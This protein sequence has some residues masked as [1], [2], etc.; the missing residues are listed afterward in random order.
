MSVGRVSP[1]M[2]ALR[3]DAGGITGTGGT[4]VSL[5]ED[6]RPSDGLDAEPEVDNEG[7]VVKRIPARRCIPGPKGYCLSMKIAGN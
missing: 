5:A 4:N 2:K 7:S 1:T 3:T 6:L